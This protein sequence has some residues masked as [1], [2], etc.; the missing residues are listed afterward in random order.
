MRYKIPSKNILIVSGPYKGYYA[1]IVERI[2]EVF[3][4]CIL[5]AS[6]REIFEPLTNIIFLFKGKKLQYIPIQTGLSLKIVTQD[7]TGNFVYTPTSIIE[8]HFPSSNPEI[9]DESYSDVEEQVSYDHLEQIESIIPLDI[10]NEF[11]ELLST[12]FNSILHMNMTNSTINL[13][14]KK[15]QD[16]FVKSRI[17]GG[18]IIRKF[19]TIAYVFVYINNMNIGYSVIYPQCRITPNDDPDFI[20]CVS[21][22]SKFLDEQEES[23]NTFKINFH[24]YVD[25]ILDY[26]KTTIIPSRPIIPIKKFSRMKVSKKTTK[27]FYIQKQPEKFMKFPSFDDTE[28]KLKIKNGIISRLK[29]TKQPRWSKPYIE[30]FVENFNDYT[31][32]KIYGKINEITEPRS[33]IAELLIPYIKEY[34]D[35]LELAEERFYLD[36]KKKS[37]PDITQDKLLSESIKEVKSRLQSTTPS[38]SKEYLINNINSIAHL[39]NIKLKEIKN[40]IKYSTH[41]GHD[42]DRLKNT[43]FIYSKIHE[44]YEE[45]KKNLDKKKIIQQLTKTLD[46][47]KI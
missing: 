36:V 13:H 18:K 17:V 43:I 8:D 30:D 29:K 37:I 6:G 23:F 32:G 34:K 26:T 35:T 21:Y 9:P 7:R 3:V 41:T 20:I 5:N 33:K 2:R 38:K 39:S 24:V 45:K 14:A 4:R 42:I 1:F 15:L 31:Q 28:V 22:T 16:I 11:A 40:S 47:T 27:K 12:F 25:V 19:L 44:I 10:S 46:D